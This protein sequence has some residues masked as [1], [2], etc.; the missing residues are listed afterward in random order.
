MCVFPSCFRFSLLTLLRQLSLSRHSK[1]TAPSKIW[2]EDFSVDAEQNFAYNVR[3]KATLQPFK[4][5]LQVSSSEDP[6]SL[7]TDV[8][9][10]I[11]K[12]ELSELKANA[13]IPGNT[14]VTS[15]T[16]GNKVVFDE[17]RILRPAS[18]LGRVH[19]A[20]GNVTVEI[21]EP[22]LVERL[23]TVIVAISALRP[24]PKATCQ[25]TDLPSSSTS[26]GQYA[27]D[28]LLAR[29]SSG[30]T[31]Y[32][33]IAQLDVL[34]AAADPNPQ[35]TQKPLRGLWFRTR[36]VAQYCQVTKHHASQHPVRTASSRTALHLEEDIIVQ[37]V[38]Y[39]NQ[40][41]DLDSKTALV[42]VVAHE[43][44]VRPVFN[45]RRFRSEGPNA[46]G[47]FK[48]FSDM[49]P[50]RAPMPETTASL[51]G[52]DY[53][54][55]RPKKEEPWTSQIKSDPFSLSAAE[56]ASSPL[57][58]PTLEMR[59][60]LRET[61]SQPSN[62]L[63]M[64]TLPLLDAR[65]DL[66]H[67]WATLVALE[68]LKKLR[69]RS[70]KS[71][72]APIPSGPSLLSHFDVQ[73][74]AH[75]LHIDLELP[76]GERLF[77]RLRKL[78][79]SLHDQTPVLAVDSILAYVPNVRTPALWDELLFLKTLKIQLHRDKLST[80][81]FSLKTAR[82]RIPVSLV[83]LTNSFA[84]YRTLTPSPLCVFAVELQALATD[85]QS[86]CDRQVA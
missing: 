86:Q 23:S 43:S 80:V 4:L 10:A 39:T 25:P 1:R 16:A 5:Y 45:A 6:S 31:L 62:H 76:L 40:N 70:N 58:I 53:Q 61:L 74:N 77:V 41:V 54:D 50:T 20:I 55:R 18:S 78:S 57:R 71:S 84:R 63:I 14:V 42:S 24:P 28:R 17:K 47:E 7:A 49:F 8:A 66:S 44:G 60:V 15:S 73:L 22:E 32:V 12:S 26:D 68:G 52:W 38:S 19:A 30:L 3:S 36:I 46:T 79:G 51:V 81:D 82:L 59:I 21:W 65:L 72:K 83:A 48:A 75:L 34:V 56:R 67:A 13:V 37:S 27:P 85:P 11:I 9:P 69:G 35:C 33:C 2:P 29:L 64:V